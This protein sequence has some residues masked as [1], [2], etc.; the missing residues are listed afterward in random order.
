MYTTVNQTL[1]SQVRLYMKRYVPRNL[2][3]KDI[4]KSQVIFLLNDQVD[5]ESNPVSLKILMKTP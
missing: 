3:V 1:D 4:V 2:I 5:K